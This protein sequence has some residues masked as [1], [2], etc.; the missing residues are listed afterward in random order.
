[1]KKNIVKSLGI[2]LA[3]VLVI[4]SLNS[5]SV[6]EL[7]SGKTER[8]AEVS[9]KTDLRDAVFTFSYGELR[10]TID[11][12]IVAAIFEDYDELGDDVT[13]DMSY[14]EIVN[15]F[16]EGENDKQFKKM[17]ALCTDEE[18]AQLTANSHEVLEYFVEHINSVKT[19]K[20]IV[21]YTEGFWTDGGSFSFKQNGEDSDSKIK[22]AA[23]YFDYFVTKGIGEYFDNADN[24][25]TG[26]TN[27]GDSL[28]DIMYL[29]GED[30][31]CR[32]TDENVKSVVS[33]L[34][35]DYT[36]YSE[37]YTDKNGKQKSRDIKIP[38]KIT[39]IITI[40]LKDD[41]QS[42]SNA[43][44]LG[45]KQAVLDE[46]KKA[47]DYFTIE[48]YTVSFDG[49]KI[50]ATFNAATD[51]ILTATYDKV[52]NIETEVTGVGSLEH[53]GKQEVSFTCTRWVDYKFGWEAE[54]E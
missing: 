3:F 36:E 22:T 14:N 45:D 35:Y 4:L 24:G 34:M 37:K 5:C 54:A 20:P 51:N 13:I 53:I 49:C 26:E 18:L 31:A 25:K 43:F 21:K 48:D 8:P 33:S 47:K 50:V 32:L 9:V 15:R 29:Y 19:E 23:K 39:R 1:M 27:K 7:I 2:I 6:S 17:M 40:I 12:D 10:N 46:M 28:N 41:E 30:V 52:M 11:S 38:V 44:S 42:V 16:E